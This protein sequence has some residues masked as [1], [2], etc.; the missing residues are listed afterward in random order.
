[1]RTEVGKERRKCREKEHM[2][3]FRGYVHVCTGFSL[4]V[5]F[6]VLHIHPAQDFYTRIAPYGTFVEYVSIAKWGKK[7]KNEKV[8]KVKPASNGSSPR[9]FY[10]WLR[11][12]V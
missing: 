11:T 3:K 10:R 9:R 7:K 12:S 1:M 8:I 2:W 5:L 6:Q 4:H